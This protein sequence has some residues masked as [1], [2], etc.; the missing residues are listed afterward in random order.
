M[1]LNPIILNTAM[2][3]GQQIWIKTPPENW[4]TE[5]TKQGFRKWIYEEYNNKENWRNGKM[6]KCGKCIECKLQHAK[7]WGARAAMEIKTSP[8][9]NWFITLTYADKYL[10]YNKWNL[11]TINENDLT[12]FIKKLRK[13][14]GEGIK[15]LAGSEYGSR[16]QRPHFHII[17]FNL[18]LNDLI[19]TGTNNNLNQKYYISKDIDKLWGKGLHIIGQVT[20]NSAN[21]VARYTLKKQSKI[22]YE[23]LNIAPEKLRMSK[24][25]GEKY[26]EKNKDNIFKYG[27]KIKAG[28]KLIET[29]IPRYFLKKAVKEG[30]EELVETWKNEIIKKQ[31]LRMEQ[32]TKKR[33]YTKILIDNRTILEQKTK[34]LKRNLK[35][36]N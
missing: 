30:K 18:K 14:Y 22:D 36:K 13:K 8:N 5:K 16:K 20:Y 3:T 27:I 11:P 33:N 34:T 2:K 6:L 26:Y 12:I 7:M 4:E 21:Y 10:T 24:G 19:E 28:E 17:F 29:P 15:Y 25:I 1:C 23:K 31:N 35:N 32:L 9:N